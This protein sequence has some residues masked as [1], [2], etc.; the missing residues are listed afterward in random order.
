MEEVET[1]DRRISEIVTHWPEI[2][3]AH[4]VSMGDSQVSAAQLNVLRRYGSCIHRYLAAATRDDHAADEL[5]QEFAFRFVRGD[6]CRAHPSKGRFR[7]YL[8]TILRNLVNDYYRLQKKQL[9]VRLDENI[10][11]GNYGLAEHGSDEF[12]ELWRQELISHAWTAL[13]N[14]EDKKSNYYFTVLRFRADHPE[15]N[16]SEMAEV[17][18]RNIGEEVSADWV[19]QKL[20]R[21]RQKFSQCLL[22]E[23]RQ[24]I[25]GN[26]H[27]EIQCELAE[28]RLLKY[29]NS[30]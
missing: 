3:A 5:S 18:S 10:H 19:R 1:S 12:L 20:H 26:Q 6:F 22:D 8:K 2:L 28:L 30:P 21:S 25:E 27:D 16:S 29:F 13:K 7:D 17:I 15:M 9:E 24:T 4:Q 11:L 14:L 23:V